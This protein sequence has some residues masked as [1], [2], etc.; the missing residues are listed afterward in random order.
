MVKRHG[1]EQDVPPRQLAQEVYL[2]W[3]SRDSDFMVLYTRN[4]ERC[5]QSRVGLEQRR[6]LEVGLTLASLFQMLGPGAC[7]LRGSG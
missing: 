7:E 5:S 4:L 1:N 3:P 6:N 2:E